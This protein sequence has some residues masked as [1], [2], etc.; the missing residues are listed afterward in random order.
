MLFFILYFISK[1]AEINQEDNDQFSNQLIINGIQ[2]ASDG[3]YT[4]CMHIKNKIH[5]LQRKYI[6][7][8][9]CCSL[10]HENNRQGNVSS[11]MEIF[12]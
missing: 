3:E 5:N 7:K 4:F 2:T 9:R 1:L 10:L 6:D 8:L 11:L 12:A